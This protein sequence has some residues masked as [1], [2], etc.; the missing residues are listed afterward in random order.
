MAH[1]EQEYRDWLRLHML[2]Q[3]MRVT[4]KRKARTLRLVDGK[5]KVVAKPS[6]EPEFTVASLQNTTP[7]GSGYMPTSVDEASMSRLRQK[8]GIGVRYWRLQERLR[9][10]WKLDEPKPP[11]GLQVGFT[12]TGSQVM[13]G[14]IAKIERNELKEHYYN[15][16]DKYMLN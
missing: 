7:A 12:L 2:S 11:K 4:P 5:W 14:S 13:Q 9:G 15:E 10:F 1:T 8:Q 16:T 3:P 6:L